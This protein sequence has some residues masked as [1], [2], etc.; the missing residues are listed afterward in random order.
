MA[1]HSLKDGK[2]STDAMRTSI[3]NSLKP[4]DRRTSMFCDSAIGTEFPGNG[5]TEHKTQTRAELSQ[6]NFLIDTGDK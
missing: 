2:Q 3:P 5:H 6:Q 4:P 1:R